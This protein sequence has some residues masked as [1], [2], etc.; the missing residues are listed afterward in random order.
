[1]VQGEEKRNII[2]FWM[3]QKLIGV[4]RK[5]KEQSMWMGILTPAFRGWIDVYPSLIFL[6]TLIVFNVKAIENPSLINLIT[7]NI[8][9]GVLWYILV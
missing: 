1:M 3:V 4:T 7:V 6:K 5:L 2:N 8:S 9:M